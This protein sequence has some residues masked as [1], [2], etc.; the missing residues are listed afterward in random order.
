MSK[1]IKLLATAAAFA[2]ASSA[3]AAIVADFELNGSLANSAGTP[4][5]LTNNGGV[6]G[7]SGITFGINQ[8]PTV[9][10]LSAL[11]A[12]TI[13]MSF[14]IDSLNGP[15]N[16]GYVKLIDFSNLSQD[17]GY[18]SYNGEFNAYPLGY[19]GAVFTAGAPV[20]L[21]VSRDIAGLITAYVNNVQIYSQLDTSNSSV[22]AIDGINP[23]SF[24]ADDTGTN[25][26]EASSGFVNY[27]R[28]FDTAIAPSQASA[29]P[30]P[31]TWTMLLLG[32]GIIG[33]AMRKRSNVRTAVSYA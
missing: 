11:S 31:A 23:I 6:L 8:G 12:Y 19:S 26:G 14:S 9:S 21:T 17:P 5:A 20:R 7:A 18:Y 33:F 4:A 24:F 27:I 10:G 22:T 15:R 2:S 3:N 29:V 16:N 25:R 32:F 1:L 28:I 30:E 13:D